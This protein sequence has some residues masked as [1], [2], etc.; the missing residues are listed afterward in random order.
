[1]N[2]K[3]EKMEENLTSGEKILVKAEQDKIT[4][5]LGGVITILLLVVWPLALLWVIFIYRVWIVSYFTNK[6]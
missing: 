1:M 2:K 4:L 6:L 5:I 3:G